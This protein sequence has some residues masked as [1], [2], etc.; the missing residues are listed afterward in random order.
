[1]RTAFTA[2]LTALAHAHDILTKTSWSGAPIEPVVEGALA[3]Y[4]T[5]QNRIT[6]EGPAVELLPRQALSLSLA[7]HELATNA[8]K[9]GAL[10]NAIGVISI[11]WSNDDSGFRFS[12]S[13]SGGPHVTDPAP[14]KKGFGSRMI[15][16]MLA[17][18]LG[19]T[20]T[21]TYRPDGILCEL[22]T[23]EPI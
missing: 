10:S 15:E 8:L 7:V 6:V 11:T 13:E 21:T 19:G 12:W 5:V 16:R 18:D 1:M 23:N 9:Y 3:P 2:R 22:R 14:E 20:V 4:R 17:N